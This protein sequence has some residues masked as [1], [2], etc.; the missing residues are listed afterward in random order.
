MSEYARSSDLPLFAS[1]A[2]AR[3]GDPE[4]SHD[5]ARRA[6]E[7]L[8]QSQEAILKVFSLH[9]SMT[10]EQL[11]RYYD[12]LARDFPATFP[13]QGP[14]GIRTRRHELVLL[15]KIHFSG[16]RDESQG[17]RRISPRIWRLSKHA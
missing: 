8:K 5:A 10:D 16:Q 17:D 3:S 6:T 2:K 11:V 1:A 15:G 14:S 4:S 9:P 7:Q 13:A 12:S